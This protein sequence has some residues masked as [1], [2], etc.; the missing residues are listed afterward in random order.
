MKLKI[1]T[2]VTGIAL[3]TASLAARAQKV[4]TE[5]TIT[6]TITT[7]RGAADAKTYFKADS[8]VMVTQTGPATVKVLSIGAGNY[9][10]I[11]VDVP[12]AGIKKAAVATPAEL[13]QFLST[14]PDL[15]FTPTTET[16]QIAGLNCKKVIAKDSKD[17]S[18]FDVWIT[19]DISTPINGLSQ[20]YTKAGGF[21]VQ[22]T[23]VQ[24]GQK[25]SVLFKSISDEKVPADTFKVPADFDKISL[26]D[27]QGLFA[28]Q[29]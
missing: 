4:Y 11:L 19:N 27:L 13:E 9:L 15:S 6:Y 1:A 23:T 25:V 16:K 26:T 10:A 14:L 12:V 5:G 2:V 29:K 22:F 21:P 28:A 18:S 8:N 20:L 24:M 17:N 7:P 3:V